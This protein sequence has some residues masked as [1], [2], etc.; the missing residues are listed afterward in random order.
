[1]KSEY[2][3]SADNGPHKF[4]PLIEWTLID[5]WPYYPGPLSFPLPYVDTGY[6]FR[7]MIGFCDRYA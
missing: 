3:T 1:M 2:A 4:N 5:V 6:K 7:E